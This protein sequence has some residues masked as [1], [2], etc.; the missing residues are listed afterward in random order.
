MVAMLLARKQCILLMMWTPHIW[1]KSRRRSMPLLRGL[2][3]I[4][5]R[6]D[7]FTFDIFETMMD[8]DSTHTHT[9]FQAIKLCWMCSAHGH[10]VMECTA[11][12]TETLNECTAKASCFC[13]HFGRWTPGPAWRLC[14][15]TALSKWFWLQTYPPWDLH[16]WYQCSLGHV[17]LDSYAESTNCQ[18]FSVSD[19]SSLWLTIWQWQLTVAV[20]EI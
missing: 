18:D 10:E 1:Q 19:D 17:E 8:I 7:C 3:N 15:A 20:S 5:C 4:M 6:H 12:L 9:H 16:S 2:V 13:R 11:C 14:I